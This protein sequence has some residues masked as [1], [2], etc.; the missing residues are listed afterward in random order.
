MK[1]E[2]EYI[3][4]IDKLMP[5]PEI[6]LEILKIAHESDCNINTLSR[7]IEKDPTLTANML[8]MANSAYFGHMKQINS[9]TDIIVRLGMETVKLI[10]ITSASAGLL[11]ASQKGYNLKNGALWRHSYATAVLAST[12][13]RH[14]GADD[15]PSIYTAAL[16]HDIGKVVLNKH[17][18]REMCNAEEPEPG[19][20]MVAYERSVL[21]TDHAR[22]G[23]ALLCKWGLPESISKPVGSHHRPGK[24][25][26][27][28]LSAEIVRLANILAEQMGFHSL[29]NTNP[30]AAIQ[31]FLN[32]ERDWPSVPNFVDNREKI[33]A[34]FFAKYN[35]TATIFFDLSDQ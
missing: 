28:P 18:L 29:D 13:C 30:L 4:H 10:A 5:C 3:K 14:A 20:T 9:V 35:E 16:L 22:V 2:E 27:E 8:K 23:E 1:V 33:I 32:E 31:E 21:R 7:N 15:E 11:R 26:N 34:E 25:E 17:L 6:A 12:L 19:M 24:D